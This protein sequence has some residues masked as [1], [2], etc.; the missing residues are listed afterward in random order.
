MSAPA[1]GRIT[2]WPSVPK[3]LVAAIGN[4]FG[5]YVATRFP[6]PGNPSG[7]IQS[8]IASG[9]G[10]VR[11]VRVGGSL[12]DRHTDQARVAVDVIHADEAQAEDLAE[13]IRTWMVDTSPIHGAGLMLDGAA[14]EVAPHEVAYTDPTV[15][16]F[17]ATYVVSSRRMG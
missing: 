6:G 8:L 3:V 10:V 15:S 14:V 9:V 17:S 2:G 12:F 7:D 4:M 16:Q 1:A 5:C 11:V 13:N